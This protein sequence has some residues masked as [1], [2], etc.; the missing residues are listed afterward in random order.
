MESAKPS[1][2]TVVLHRRPDAVAESL[3]TGM[4]REIVMELRDLRRQD[5]SDRLGFE[6]RIVK[7]EQIAE[8]YYY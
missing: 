2:P 8:K 5:P 7:R 4:E 6:R 3:A 1:S